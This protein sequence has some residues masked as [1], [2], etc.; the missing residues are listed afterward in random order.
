MKLRAESIQVVLKHAG[1]V[2][3]DEHLVRH[4]EEQGA[5]VFELA[6][7]LEDWGEGRVDAVPCSLG[8]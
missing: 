8:D 2:V 4:V 3:K 1:G 5:T 6:R 7:G